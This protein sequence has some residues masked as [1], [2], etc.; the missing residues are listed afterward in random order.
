LAVN[1]RALTL[2]ADPNAVTAS[3][4]TNLELWLQ[5]MAKALEGL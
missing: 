5:S 1:V 4:Y 2:P 3:G